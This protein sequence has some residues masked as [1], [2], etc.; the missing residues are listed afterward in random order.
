MRAEMAAGESLDPM[1]S[2]TC[3][4]TLVTEQMGDG[5]RYGKAKRA[6]CCGV[7]DGPVAYYCI[8][9]RGDAEPATRLKVRA[10][11]NGGSEQAMLKD[12][13]SYGS[14]ETSTEYEGQRR[15]DRNG[16]FIKSAWIIGLL[17]LAVAAILGYIAFGPNRTT[18]PA[19]SGSPAS[20]IVQQSSPASNKH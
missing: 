20:G 1:T 15:P 6:S 17:A 9:D 12:T 11:K 7:P 14:T 2:T 10:R 16:S 18:D 13:D 3:G 4:M 8:P 5:Y 19:P